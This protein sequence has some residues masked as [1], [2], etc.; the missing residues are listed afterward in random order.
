MG[1]D[2]KNRRAET[3]T[4]AGQHVMV[5]GIVTHA[6]LEV[7]RVMF[8]A[9]PG[10]TSASCCNINNE[11]IDAVRVRPTAPHTVPEQCP[12]CEGTGAIEACD[13]FPAMK[14]HACEPPSE[15]VLRIVHAF[16]DQER[17]DAVREL[18]SRVKAT[19]AAL[20]TH[21]RELQRLHW[22]RDVV[23][24]DVERMFARAL[25]EKDGREQRR[26][27]AKDQ[28]RPIHEAL[29]H[30]ETA[31]ARLEPEKVRSI[32][33]GRSLT[34]ILT[35]IDILEELLPSSSPDPKRK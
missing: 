13:P 5:R 28:S 10:A 33:A 1:D 15:D 21:R 27:S 7:S 35:A 16:D 18:G 17:K 29:V 32:V 3:A 11:D 4:T 9:V 34:D 31:K 6:G 25:K 8:A 20:Q 14:C 2:M 26:E 30:L 22:M 23:G 24:V 12:E 19:E